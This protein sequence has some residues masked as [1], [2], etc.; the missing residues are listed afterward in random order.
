[1]PV[2]PWDRRRTTKAVHYDRKECIVLGTKAVLAT[3]IAVMTLG[4]PVLAQASV[5]HSGIKE[6]PDGHMCFYSEPGFHGELSHLE[7]IDAHFCGVVPG[8]LARSV[9]NKSNTEWTVFTAPG[10]GGE[11]TDVNPVVSCCTRLR[12]CVAGTDLE[13]S[14]RPRKHGHRRSPGSC[15]CACR[16]SSYRLF[17]VVHR[18]A[19]TEH[20]ARG[21]EPVGNGRVVSGITRPV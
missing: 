21:D 15:R 4:S 13:T 14:D 1:V 16:A 8:A 6:C 3:A 2:A 12:A 20:R 17:R 19:G 9:V 11:G 10:C 7:P 18:P 5:A